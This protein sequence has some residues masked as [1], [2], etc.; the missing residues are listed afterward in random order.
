MRGRPEPAGVRS[1][2][3]PRSEQALVASDGKTKGFLPTAL[4]RDSADSPKGCSI[5][6]MGFVTCS[7]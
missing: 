3:K 4:G 2:L 7:G 6:G 1:L 5:Q